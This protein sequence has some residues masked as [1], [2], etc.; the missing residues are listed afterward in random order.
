MLPLSLCIALYVSQFSY[1]S[2]LDKES[3]AMDGYDSSTTVHFWRVL[4]VTLTVEPMTL[5]N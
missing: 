5:K 4:P 3:A 2:K 1:S